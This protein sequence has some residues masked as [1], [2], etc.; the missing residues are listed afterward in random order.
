MRKEKF[1]MIPASE[2]AEM[3]KDEIKKYSYER[4]FTKH[5]EFKDDK[6][7]E[8][9]LT[10]YKTYTYGPNNSSSYIYYG[11]YVLD[12]GPY[13]LTKEFITHENLCQKKAIKYCAS[14]SEELVEKFGKD[15]DNFIRKEY[16]AFVDMCVEAHNPYNVKLVVD[17]N[18]SYRIGIVDIGNYAPIYDITSN[19][20]EGILKFTV[21]QDVKGEYDIMDISSFYMILRKL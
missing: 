21:A 18:T 1:L 11:F 6:G 16:K 8:Y 19:S 13:N 4:N 9:N 15:A 10:I 17:E 14:P 2:F 12:K 20:Y 7:E 3:L 5:L